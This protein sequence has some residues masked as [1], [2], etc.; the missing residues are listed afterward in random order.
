MADLYLG[1]DPTNI[2]YGGG[3][4]MYWKDKT[5]TGWL[6][7]GHFEAL[8]VNP[9][10]T[11]E[12]LPGSRRASRGTIKSRV[13][14]RKVALSITPMELSTENVRMMV[15]AEEATQSNQLSSYQDLAALTVVD[16]AY[17]R[18]GH[19]DVSITRIPVG[20][21]SD[22]P[23]EVGET[24]TGGTS[25]AT[26]K[27]A[28]TATGLLE[29]VNVSGTFVAG[30]TITGGSS[31]ASAT[32]ASVQKVKDLVVVDAASPTTRYELG[33]DYDLEADEGMVRVLSTG[34]I[35]GNPYVAYN[36]DALSGEILYQFSGGN[37]INKEVLI[38]TDKDNDGPRYELYY[39]SVDWT[40][41][42]EWG[43]LID[44]NS[45][46]PFEG[47]VLEDSTQASGQE[48]GYVKMLKAA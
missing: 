16:D 31:T 12:E 19:N 6:E 44:G 9:S 21:I 29:L 47:T 23:F 25:S 35:S 1:S 45:S 2:Q 22:G 5:D 38:V 20:T 30:E 7:V 24:V 3:M 27:V 43:L 26:G 46:L 39:P 11:K 8:S 18:L 40:P 33:T 48:Y 32:S 28:W 34:D 36:Y 15:L 10:V 17:V 13:T 42:G 14:E 37:V 41:N 4:R